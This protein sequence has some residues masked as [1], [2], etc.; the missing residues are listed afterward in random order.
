M[1]GLA[2]ALNAPGRIDLVAVALAPRGA[3]GALARLETRSGCPLEI[4]VRAEIP[5]VARVADQTGTVVA[6]IAV[7]GIAS[8]TAIDLG[9]AEHG[10]LG[11]LDGELPYAV[12]VADAARDVLV[13]ARTVS[14]PGLYYARQDEGWLVASEPEALVRAGVAAEPDGEVIVDFIEHGAADR[15]DRTFFASIR[16]VADGTAVVLGLDGVAEVHQTPA[17][18]PGPES[19]AEPI[20]EIV[21]RGVGGGR[22]GVL[23]G[24]GLGG[25]AVLG[26]ALSR[27]DRARPLPV[28]TATFPDLAGPAAHTPAVLVPLPYGAVR[29]TPHTFDAAHLDL[30]RYL[31]DIGEPAP[32]LAVCLSWAVARELDGEVDTLVNTAVSD[33]V[34]L[35][36][37]SDR[38]AARYGVTIRSPLST[39]DGWEPDEEDLAQ[40]VDRTLPGAVGR[41]ARN[42]SAEPLGAADILRARCPDV[43]AALATTRP[44]VDRYRLLADLRR[45]LR[46][47]DADAERLWRAYLVERWLR[48]V[49]AA[50]RPGDP[51]AGAAAS[52]ARPAEP[53]V[54]DADDAVAGD[55]NPGEGADE[56]V[57]GAVTWA[58]LPVRTHVIA[59]GDEVPRTAAWSTA[60]AVAELGRTRAYQDALP[61]PWFAVLAGKVVAVGQ[62][63]V[64]P[65]WEIE[66]GWLARGIARVAARREPRLA[67]AWTVQVVIR[68]AGLT[69]AVLGV[70]AAMLPGWWPHRLRPRP[71]DL[72]YPPRWDAVPPSAEA[73][74]RAPVNPGEVAGAVL[75]ALRHQLAPETFDT[76]AGCAVASVDAMTARVLGFA[77]GPGAVAFADPES[78]LTEVLADNPAGQGAEQTPVLVVCEAPRPRA[79]MPHGGERD[80]A[81]P[82]ARASGARASRDFAALD[83]S[84]RLRTD[85]DAPGSAGRPS[86]GALA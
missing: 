43:A 81:A 62:R 80:P 34:A 65:L 25:A 22:A 50:A 29:H 84:G 67:A 12:V 78:L 2:G 3:D 18:A 56:I 1:A 15:D 64:C 19:P 10:P 13:L 79:S 74:V 75:D 30:D 59:P 35:V 20:W 42:D 26:T 14:G 39:S 52:S 68:D 86:S 54:G 21:Q 33:A 66:P 77:P 11:L 55:V 57:A 8:V 4:A 27:P 24:P 49:G 63:R 53:A 32:D 28:H 38:L 7:D 37:V 60:R 82:G 36:R 69:R 5:A 70:L 17:P 40:V 73:V 71:M 51:A 9:Y 48:T 76:L 16:R 58:R 61:G 46:G 31:A 85:G 47:E 83:A 45:L 72:P 44:W 23:L 6:A 41:Y